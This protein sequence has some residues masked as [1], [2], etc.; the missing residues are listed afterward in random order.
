ALT[1]AREGA[2]GKAVIAK[3]PTF[4]PTA[5]RAATSLLLRKPEWTA[6]LLDGIESGTVN[7]R[8]LRPEN[9]QVLKASPEAAIADRA[10]KLG[11]AK[12]REPNADKKKLLDSLAPLAQKTGDVAIGQAAFEKNCAVCH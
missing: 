5:Q 7:A 2:A 12:G 11:Q 1:L 4:S 6:A 8:D 10:A 3:W 9:W